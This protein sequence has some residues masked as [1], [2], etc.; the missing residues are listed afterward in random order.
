MSSTS[1]PPPAAT[2]FQA[3]TSFLH[4]TFALLARQILKQVQTAFPSHREIEI[5]IAVEIGHRNLHA[6][7]GTRGVFDGV[8]Y[9]IELAIVEF[10]RLVPVDAERFSLPRVP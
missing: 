9:P 6:A 5:A 3:E 10:D 7:A 4:G 1:V 8:P 2:S